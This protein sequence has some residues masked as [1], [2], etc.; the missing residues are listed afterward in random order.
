MAPRQSSN[1]RLLLL[2]EGM[3]TIRRA[4]ERLQ[5]L[6]ADGEVPGFIHLSIGQEA[7]PVG[8]SANLG[9]ADTVASNHRGHGHALAKGIDLDGFFA[10]LMGR[11]TGL[12]RG[13]GGS[14]HVADVSIG[15]L[16]ANGIV[17]AGLPITLGSALAHRTRGN[18]AVAVAYFGDGALAEGVLH[19]C[20]NIA[21]LWRLPMLFA[22]ENNGWSEFSPTD[23]Q[24]K[25]KLKDLA[26]AF[27][28]PHHDVDGNDVEAVAAAARNCIAALRRGD[29]P[30]V[31]ECH[32]TRVRG[33]YEGDRQDYRAPDELA[34]LAEVDP[35]AR[36]STRLLAAGVEKA[37]LDAISQAVDGR[38]AQA[39]ERAR[40]AP[41]PEFGD[42]L[43]DVY[44]TAAGG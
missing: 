33:H 11:E 41:E 42:A 12:C 8:I 36:C 24:M 27:S 4:E 20:L 37:R 25:A 10:E 2:Y 32:T 15:M 17:G 23:R 39:V 6:F 16:G 3:L 35:V 1:D 21:A 30:R 29:G 38:I 44:T 7:V 14:M 34:G 13:R 18:D 43:A 22:C 26:G 9:P 31:L 19:E 5:A 40:A 28:I